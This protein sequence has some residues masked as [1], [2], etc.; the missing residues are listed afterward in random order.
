MISKH[1]AKPM[2]W[3]IIVSVLGLTIAP[4]T[5]ANSEFKIFS[6]QHRFAEELLPT[7]EA[8]VNNQGTASAIQNQLIVR[9]DRR[10]MAEV[11]QAISALDT[12]RENLTIRVK[13]Q[14][15]RITTSD[16]TTIKGRTRI[17]N[18]TINNSSD[19]KIRRDGIN[20]GLENNEMQS[21][22]SSEQFIQAS[23]DAP[24]YISVGESV[25]YTSEWLSL[26]Q[27]Y[28]VIQQTTE[29][30]EIGTGFTVRARRINNQVEIDITPTLSRL[31]HHGKLEFEQ[32]TTTV[33]IQRG[34]W[35]NI[36]GTMQEMDDVS[37][38][39][40]S[41]RNRQLYENNQ[42]MIRVE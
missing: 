22:H 32:L 35:L 38:A 42:I 12:A 30:I 4:L 16:N 13:R 19:T 20:I 36:G 2:L 11:E 3:L 25:P 15:N 41:S 39:I 8:I 1:P 33:R 23:E 18:V 7:I 34:E 28:A 37:R 27:R 6:L 24:A 9:T 14:S 40:L 5:H 21:Q 29:F 17:G 26:T 10:T 31:T